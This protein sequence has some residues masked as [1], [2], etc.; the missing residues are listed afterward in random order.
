[1]HLIIDITIL[2]ELA[3][4]FDYDGRI[5][6]KMEGYFETIE[7]RGDGIVGSASG[8]LL[9]LEP[10]CPKKIFNSLLCLFQTYISIFCPVSLDFFSFFGLQGLSSRGLWWSALMM[11]SPLL[12]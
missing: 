10:C 11:A 7:G 4:L 3:S 5:N 2:I 9:V 6:G 1:M 8:L 12:L